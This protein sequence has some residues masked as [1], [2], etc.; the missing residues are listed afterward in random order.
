MSV[1]S[2]FRQFH[3]KRT[4][5]YLLLIALFIHSSAE[6]KPKEL[7]TQTSKASGT[8]APAQGSLPQENPSASATYGPPA[9]DAGPARPTT[10]VAIPLSL[11]LAAAL[12]A[13]THPLVD[14]AEAEANALA[15]EYRGA[16]RGRYPSLSV[17]ALAATSGST[18]A[19]QDGLALNAAIEQPIWAGGRISGEIVRARASLRAGE[20]RVDEA[21]RQIVVSVVRAYYD[22]VQADERLSVLNDSLRQHNELLASIGRRVDQEVSPR[23]DIT[24]GRSRTAQVELDLASTQELL[25]IARLR[26]IELTGGLDVQPTLPPPSVVEIL[27]PEDVALA[28]AMG[29]D[30]SLAVLT[31]L[32]AASE[33]QR[34]IAKA[35]LLPQVLLQLSQNEIT[36]ARAA[37]VL[38]MQLANGASEFT[39]VES[40]DA[41]IKRAL[42]DYG[43]AQRR[44]REEL[45]REYI[46]VR[47]SSARI[48]VSAL[49]AD[50][51]DQIIAS[52][53]R[54]FIAGRRSW[55]DVMNAVREAASARLSESDARVM[56]AM[57]TARILA[58]T[59]RWQPDLAE[60]PQ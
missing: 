58:L 57:G 42:A 2:S 54:Q 7:G 51:A 30:P 8:E 19:D 13:K 37:V 49:S 35:Q 3:P 34:D 55:L 9:V 14:A 6:L 28:E 23:I 21:Q 47:A 36:G 16:K 17:E 33:A 40:S 38:R 45:R 26:L 53:K 11:D 56:A 25:E 52:Y 4:I 60:M 22:F 59:C 48:E 44:Q 31:G 41:R 1:S 10:P 46:L 12:A 39:N 43:E 27:P 18:F 5:T 32:I 20:N 15:A 24:L 29:C 50:A